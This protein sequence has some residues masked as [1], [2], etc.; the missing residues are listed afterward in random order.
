MLKS[1]ETPL[2]VQEVGQGLQVWMPVVGILKSNSFGQSSTDI[3][4]ALANVAKKLCVESNQTNSHEAFLATKHKPL[5]KNPGLRPIGVGKV[6]RRIT[7]KALVHTMK[8][9]I[10]RSVGNLQEW[11]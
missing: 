3:C 1:F 6:I 9:N 10:I 8:E 4:I 2:C 11:P 5:D 7:G